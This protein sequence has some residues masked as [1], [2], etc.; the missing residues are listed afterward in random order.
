MASLLFPVLFVCVQWKKEVSVL[1]PNKKTVFPPQRTSV[2]LVEALAVGETGLVLRPVRVLLRLLENPR[3]EGEL[4]GA[5]G[6]L[7][8]AHHGQVVGCGKK[9]GKMMRKEDNVN[10]KEIKK[11]I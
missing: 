10:N 6:C 4:S 7:Y 8:K 11:V 3:N 9:K 1:I 2:P 5:S